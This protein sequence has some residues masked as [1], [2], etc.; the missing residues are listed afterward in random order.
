MLANH[1]AHANAPSVAGVKGVSPPPRILT[2][3]RIN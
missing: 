3:A 1:G 2:E